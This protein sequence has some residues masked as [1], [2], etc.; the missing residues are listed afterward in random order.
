MDVHRSTVSRFLKAVR[1]SAKKDR[2]HADRQNAELRMAW[3]ASLLNITAEQIVA[4]DES[5]FE[6]KEHPLFN[7]TTSTAPS[8]CLKTSIP[9]LSKHPLGKTL[10][11]PAQVVQ[12]QVLPAYQTIA[13]SP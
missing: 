8:P 10:T 13:F 6:Y 3:I 9:N 12:Q 1:L 4:V 2:R 5:D 7:T 11:R